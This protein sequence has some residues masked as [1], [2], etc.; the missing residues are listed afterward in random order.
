MR[1]SN[2]RRVNRWVVG[3]FLGYILS[4]VTFVQPISAAGAFSVESLTLSNPGVSA[5][6][7]VTYTFTF[8]VATTATIIQSFEAKACTTAAGACTTPAGFVNTSSLNQPTG[9]GDASGWTANNAT[10]GALRLVKSGDASTPSASSSTVTFTNVTNPT[11]VGTFFM[12]MTSFSDAAWT[13]PIDSGNTTSSIVNAITVTA[14]IDETLTFCVY[15][16]GGTCADTSTTPVGLGTLSIASTKTGTSKMDAATNAA[17]GLSI[18]YYGDTLK[19]IGAQSIAAIGN[20][21]TTS[22]IGTSQFGINLAAN[23][24]PAVG[25]APSGG[26]VVATAP[27][28]GLA[29]N[30]NKFAYV[31]STATTP[32]PIASSGGLP[33]NSTTMTISY[34]ANITGSQAAGNYSTVVTYICSATF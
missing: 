33:S 13:T 30:V 18:T 15:N 1:L 28:D 7:T 17:G 10:A 8:K 27:Y 29:G 12:R 16:S 14:T 2:R 24:T 11:S 34:I 5:G 19:N 6:A 26:S 23:T 32:Q 20:T 3:T 9:L 22:N 21:A 31:V 4:A 25:S